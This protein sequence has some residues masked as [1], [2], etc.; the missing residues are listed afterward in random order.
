[1]GR[2]ILV[3]G[4]RG[5]SEKYPENTLLAFRKAIEAGADGIEL[6]VWLTKDGE[7]VVIHDETVDRTSNGSGKVKEMTLA[8]LRELDFGMGEG[9][10]T[11]EE[12]FEALPEN[13][14]VNVEIKDIDAVKKTAEIIGANNP[15]RVIVSSF[16][17]DALREYRKLDSETRL[18]VLLDREEVLAQLPQLIAELRPWSINPP[19]EA[20]SVVGVEKTVKELE[21]AKGAGLKVL[22]W[23]LKD[24]SYYS[25]DSLVRLIPLFDGVIV[26]DV[27]R[28]LG[29]LKKLGLR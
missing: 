18:G 20:L 16:I 11:L 29:Y 3:L 25:N 7:V 23:S 14:V 21:K 1:M 28:M 12:V 26:D 8:E 9:I 5:Y 17:I 10:P 15:E 2:N 27:E 4:H 22:L 19:I 13:A 6:D 24:E